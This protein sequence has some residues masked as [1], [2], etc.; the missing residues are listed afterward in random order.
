MFNNRA[1]PPP[2]MVKALLTFCRRCIRKSVRLLEKKNPRC[3]SVMRGTYFNI[4]TA[5]GLQS[6]P[7]QS[8]LDGQQKVPVVSLPQCLNPCYSGE[9]SVSWCTTTLVTDISGCCSFASLMALAKALEVNT[10]HQYRVVKAEHN[11][12]LSF[13][14]TRIQRG[15]LP[16]IWT[17][18]RPRSKLCLRTI[19]TSSTANA[20]N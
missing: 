1:P 9:I 2:K 6:S 8:G 3:L 11:L 15:F 7:V 13:K 14:M 17:A 19:P 4:S 18:S 5:C 10:V 20:G 16:D 12:W